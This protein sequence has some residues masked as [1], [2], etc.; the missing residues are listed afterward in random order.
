MNFSSI[1]KYGG[2][3]VAAGA[4]LSFLFSLDYMFNDKRRLLPHIAFCSG[5]L[6]TGLI[7][8]AFGEIAAQLKRRADA[9]E[10]ANRIAASRGNLDRARLVKD[11]VQ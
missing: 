6:A 10:E 2:L 3:V 1:A 8:S 9:A 7:A 11:S 5:V 4:V